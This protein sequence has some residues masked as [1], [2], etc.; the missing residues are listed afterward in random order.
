[1]NQFERLFPVLRDAFSSDAP[2]TLSRLSE[3]LANARS[4]LALLF[5]YSDI[6]DVTRDEIKKGELKRA[7]L[8]LK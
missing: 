4:R 3:G 2:E 7:F 6:T 1:M 8:Y 5:D